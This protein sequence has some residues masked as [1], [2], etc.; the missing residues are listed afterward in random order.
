MDADIEQLIRYLVAHLKCVACQ[1]QYSINDFEVLEEGAN[2][3]ILLMT[4]HHCQAQGLLMAF[5]QEQ[6]TDPRRVAQSEERGE[7][8]CISTDDVLDMHRFLEGFE[9]DCIALVRG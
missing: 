9:G 1:H 5:V 3:L 2:T 8:E 7:L 6:E 4:C